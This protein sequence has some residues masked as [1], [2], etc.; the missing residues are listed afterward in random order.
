MTDKHR[1]PG[2]YGTTM[3]KYFQ[4]LATAAILIM[5]L[6]VI[7]QQIEKNQSVLVYYMPKT[8]ILVDVEY[9]RIDAQT[10]MF[11]LYSK[12]YLGTE[13]VV[14]EDKV[15]YRIKSINFQ[16][17]TIADKKHQYSLTA[18]KMNVGLTLTDD[19]ILCGINTACKT[20]VK[21]TF[22]YIINEKQVNNTYIVPLGEEQMMSGSVAKM[23]ENTAKQIYRIRENRLNLLSGEVD[24]MPTDGD[25]LKLI[26]DELNKQEEA[27]CNL[28]VGNKT[29]S[30][31]HA[32]Y[33]LDLTKEYSNSVLFRFSTHT[34]PV[35][36]E[37]LS[38]FP[39]TISTSISKVSY[40]KATKERKAIDNAIY[41]NIPGTADITI[42]QGEKIMAKHSLK[43]AQLG[44]NVPL[45]SAWLN[46]KICINP[47]TGLIS[48]I[49]Q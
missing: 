32:Y 8:E 5:P 43:V 42:M 7:A 20:E 4:L 15:T 34:G 14:K 37:D 12:R 3:N 36:A 6:S 25:A 11:Y 23:A 39:I 26:L 41:Y 48:Q 31:Y 33:K 27:L 19:G 38:G 22:D 28:F 29:V 16:T 46:K 45:E 47:Q 9:E 24:K 18:G 2:K 21:N 10:G 1:L 30:T 17:R 40:A 35:E 13:D 44:I 49:E